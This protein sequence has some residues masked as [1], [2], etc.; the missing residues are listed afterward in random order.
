MITKE[1]TREKW[2]VESGL[3]ALKSCSFEL[4]RSQTR[5]VEQLQAEKQC[6]SC[7]YTF[8]PYKSYNS[9]CLAT[10]WD[11]NSGRLKCSKQVVDGIRCRYTCWQ[12][13]TLLSPCQN[14]DHRLCI[15]KETVVAACCRKALRT[16]ISTDGQCAMLRRRAFSI[17][18]FIPIRNTFSFR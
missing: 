1:R 18:L 8:S 4:I 17:S 6:Q 12:S 11:Q 15:V 3:F 16:S 9:L 13:C 7:C 10:L 14:K 2:N 5:F